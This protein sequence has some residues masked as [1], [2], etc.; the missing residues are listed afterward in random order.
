[1]I[2][3]VSSA[4]GEPIFFAFLKHRL[5]A[6]KSRSWTNNWKQFHYIYANVSF[7]I[8]KKMQKN[9]YILDAKTAKPK[10]TISKLST[11]ELEKNSSPK[12]AKKTYTSTTYHMQNLVQEHV[13][14][15]MYNYVYVYT[16]VT[17]HG[18]LCKDFSLSVFVLEFLSTLLRH[19]HE[20][21][22]APHIPTRLVDARKT[23]L[24]AVQVIVEGIRPAIC[25]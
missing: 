20:S 23:E 17:H 10:F 13:Y 9:Y 25:T 2:F 12:T 19:G 24:T 14:V 21:Q 22:G 1:M 18:F 16:S 11:K 8:F 15:H 3:S 4:F 7:C 6:P 5:A